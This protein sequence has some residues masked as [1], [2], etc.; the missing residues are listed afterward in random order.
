MSYVYVPLVMFGSLGAGVG[1]CS[2]EPLEI[3]SRISVATVK[4][5]GMDLPAQ[6]TLGH[7]SD[8]WRF[9]TTPPLPPLTCVS[10]PTDS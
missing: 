7:G 3:K 4:D 5:G 8:M 10:H 9:V 1:P 6:P 2:S